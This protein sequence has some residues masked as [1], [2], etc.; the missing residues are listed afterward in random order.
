MKKGIAV[1]CLISSILVIG[2]VAFASVGLHKC[3]TG[4]GLCSGTCEC[5]GNRESIQEQLCP[6]KC[7]NPGLPDYECW[8][9]N[10]RCMDM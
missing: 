8:S 5:W 6:F 9:Q 4:Q 10:G 2:A 7:T 1:F 3:P